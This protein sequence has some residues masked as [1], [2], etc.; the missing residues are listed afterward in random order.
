[1]RPPC[2]GGEW[3]PHSAA[4]QVSCA[5]RDGHCE[6][7]PPSARPEGHREIS[8]AYRVVLARQNFRNEGRQ[9]FQNSQAV[10]RSPLQAVLLIEADD[11]P[12]VVE[13]SAFE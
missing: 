1:M 6:H 9:N 12:D 4:I 7:P 8:I 11:L 2:H 3:Q 10:Y 13:T 5:G